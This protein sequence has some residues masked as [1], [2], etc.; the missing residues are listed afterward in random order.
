MGDKLCNDKTPTAINMWQHG[1]KWVDHSTLEL[2]SFSLVPLQACKQNVL[3]LTTLILLLTAIYGPTCMTLPH[4]TTWPHSTTSWYEQLEH[5]L[6]AS[7]CILFPTWDIMAMIKTF[8]TPYLP[9]IHV[10]LGFQALGR[11]GGMRSAAGKISKDT[12]SVKNRCNERSTWFLAC[13]FHIEHSMKWQVSHWKVKVQIIQ[14][15]VW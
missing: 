3:A 11:A 6:H 14:Q 2:P 10:A 5:Q 7:L 15:N 13:K 8:L 1:T 9:L 12:R 4:F